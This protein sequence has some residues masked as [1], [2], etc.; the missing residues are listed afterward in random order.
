M[1]EG[2]AHA[3]INGHTI[4]QA[5]Y[6]R[7]QQQLQQTKCGL[8]RQE[9]IMIEAHQRLDPIQPI[10]RCAGYGLVFSLT[11][12]VPLNFYHSTNLLW[13]SFG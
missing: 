2:G 10:G 5:A 8:E 7:A 9:E 6:E 11:P 13:T 3:V 1:S 4:N 12:N